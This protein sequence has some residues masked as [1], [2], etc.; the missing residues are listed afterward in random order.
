ML[1]APILLRHGQF[2]NHNTTWEACEVIV[3][4]EGPTHVYY[5][6]SAEMCVCAVS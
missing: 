4:V 5:P 1:A 6:L 3:M 2:L